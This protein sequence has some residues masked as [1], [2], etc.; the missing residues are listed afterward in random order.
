MRLIKSLVTILLLSQTTYGQIYKGMPG[1][2]E[3]PK[4]H[5]AFFVDS[6]KKSIL[7]DT[8]LFKRSDL[9]NSGGMTRNTKSYSKLFVVNDHYLYK[10]DIVNGTE[11][12]QFADA[13]L[14]VNDIARIGYL[15]IPV[16]A[17]LF[18]SSG[19]SGV[20]IISL[21]KTKKFNPNIA[22]YKAKK[23]SNF[24]QYQKGDLILREY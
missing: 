4:E 18:G 12:R 3:V 6:L 8:N 5:Y 21:K 2:I 16:S 17:A 14:N 1:L 11:V 13:V 24:D 22:G 23:N 19:N 20:I 7:R 15:D 10:L 9:I